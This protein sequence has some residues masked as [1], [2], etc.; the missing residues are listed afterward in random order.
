MIN[1]NEGY[2]RSFISFEPLRKLLHKREMTDLQLARKIGEKVGVVRKIE[3]NSETTTMEVIRKICE[4]LECHPGDIMKRDE[5][6]VI[7]ATK[8]DPGD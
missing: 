1:I 7:P 6:I 5:L 2:K 3:L 8:K 4:V